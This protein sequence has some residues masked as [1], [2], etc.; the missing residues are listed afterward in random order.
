MVRFRGGQPTVVDQESS[1]VSVKISGKWETGIA[2]PNSRVG[3]AFFVHAQPQQ[4]RLAA[5]SIRK[6]SS[7]LRLGKARPVLHLPEISTEMCHSPCST[8]FGLPARK[9]TTSGLAISERCEGAKCLRMFSPSLLTLSD[10]NT[11]CMP[12]A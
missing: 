3:L 1:H 4:Q 11:M 6:T 9:L 10:V 8:T 2:S 12:V 7:T 5:M